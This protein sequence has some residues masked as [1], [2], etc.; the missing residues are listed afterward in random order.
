MVRT[1]DAAV[2]HV[3]ADGAGDHGR[4]IE[5]D[6]IVGDGLIETA[7]DYS[8]N[9]ARVAGET[10]LD[11][12]YVIRTSVSADNMGPEQAVLNDKKLADVERAFRTTCTC[13]RSAIASKAA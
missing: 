5:H 6:A 2:I 7:F 8:I 10:A 3:L 11:G 4:T 13:V 9:A 12:L 1:P